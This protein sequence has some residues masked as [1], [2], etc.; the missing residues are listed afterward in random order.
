LI[1]IYFLVYCFAKF[2]KNNQRDLTYMYC[3]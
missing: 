3:N 2:N 1:I